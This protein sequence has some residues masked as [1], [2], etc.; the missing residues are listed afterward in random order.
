MRLHQH[1]SDHL[2]NK[3]LVKPDQL[4]VW[5]QVGSFSNVSVN[6]ST[7]KT[8]QATYTVSLIISPLTIAAADLMATI[9][10][11]ATLT[12]QTNPSI[13]FTAVIN[14]QHTQDLYLDIRVKEQ[15]EY[16]H[17]PSSGKLVLQPLAVI[18]DGKAFQGVQ[19]KPLVA[20]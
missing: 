5:V 20:S 15:L 1:L 17:E 11:W 2:I 10:E 3:S 13:D 19:F 4:T 7:S 14:D 16:R 6:S 18:E 8:Y 12:K 9:S